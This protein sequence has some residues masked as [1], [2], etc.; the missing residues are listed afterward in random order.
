ME[1]EFDKSLAPFNT[2]GL[3]VK[4]AS[5]GVVSS[6][7]ELVQWLK[8]WQGEPPFILG[9][10]SNL[11]LTKDFERVVLKN[12]IK[13]KRISSFDEDNK[14]LLTVGG[15]ENW[16]ELV[17]YSL[18]N[19]LGGI[20]NLSLIPGTVG[21]APIQNIG[22]YGVELCDVFNHLEAVHLQ[23]GE[24]RLFNKEECQFAYRNSIFKQ[25]LK[26]QYCITAVGLIL[27][28]CEHQCSISYGAIQQELAL[29]GVN[30]P[31]PK[32]ISDV[33]ISIRSRKLPD[34]SVLG[35]SG[36]FFKNPVVSTDV[37]DQLL[38]KYP[39]M[40]HYMLGN[41]QVKIPAG[42]LIEQAGWKGKRIGDAGTYDKQALVLVNHGHATGK[43]LWFFAQLLI[44]A[45][46]AKF[47]IELR[48]EVNVL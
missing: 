25:E 36:S 28:R 13:G 8:S 4:A 39:S 38:A 35:N 30:D 14:V 19:G 10:G 6:E 16:H 1:I 27:T 32:D 40:P 34:P 31:T 33:V 47:G 3:D 20:E 9:G 11:L 44:K 23:T 5:F 42:W 37:F 26:G 29:R 43:G 48:P 45:V 12:E 17:L 22:A 2:F 18:A 24:K 21:A 7:E 15:G 41:Q 46:K